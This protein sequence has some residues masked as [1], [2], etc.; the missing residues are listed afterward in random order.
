[1]SVNTR[2]PRVTNQQDEEVFN[3]DIAYLG[4]FLDDMEFEPLES[5]STDHDPSALEPVSAE[6]STLLAISSNAPLLLHPPELPIS[7]ATSTTRVSPASSVCDGSGDDA[8]LS[9]SVSAY[10]TFGSSVAKTLKT[11]A[12]PA[13][14]SSSSSED[15]AAQKKN[16]RRE[17]NREHAKTCRSRK[18]NYLKSLEESVVDLKRE[19]DKLRRL[20]MI[21]F[22]R[23]EIA[24]FM[25][26]VPS[27]EVYKKCDG[28]RHPR[29]AGPNE[30]SSANASDYLQSLREGC[31]DV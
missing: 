8:S 4:D 26:T 27:S 24:A 30:V 3:V 23:E 18:K 31:A 21:K 10:V 1:M 12:S 19:N 5:L 17:R 28:V 20:M 13:T 6:S 16:R 11:K 29:N 15:A 25:K 9:N 14:H 22:T 7:T 2:P